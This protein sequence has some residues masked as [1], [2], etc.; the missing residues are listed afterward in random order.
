[1][2]NANKII[3]IIFPSSQSVIIKIQNSYRRINGG[4]PKY[5]NTD[6]ELQV[7]SEKIPEAGELHFLYFIGIGDMYCI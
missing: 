4:F 2:N 5:I 7:S 1:M 3:Y 6:K